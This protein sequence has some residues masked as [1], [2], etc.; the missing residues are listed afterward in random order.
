[1]QIVNDIY[2]SSAQQPN[3]VSYVTEP[4]SLLPQNW[5]LVLSAESNSNHPIDFLELHFNF[6]L[7]L[8]LMLPVPYFTHFSPLKNLSVFSFI[9]CIPSTSRI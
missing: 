2:N 1:M 4:R 6:I 8:R 5:K 7:P 3:E 9:S